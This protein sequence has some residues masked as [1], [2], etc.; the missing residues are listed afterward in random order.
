MLEERIWEKSLGRS[1]S[2][3]RHLLPLLP[4][5]WRLTYLTMRLSGLKTI[6]RFV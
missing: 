5:A 2:S 1:R 4:A 6:K 3:P